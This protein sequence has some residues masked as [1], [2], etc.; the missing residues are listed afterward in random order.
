VF[1][2][3]KNNKP[4]KDRAVFKLERKLPLRRVIGKLKADEIHEMVVANAPEIQKGEKGYPGQF[5]KAL[6]SFVE[7]LTAE[8]LDEME[9]I[10]EEWQS[11]GP[12]VDVRLK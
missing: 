12:P 5:Q 10:R 11:A 2:W 7:T 8:E 6:T 3:F 9:K 4:Y 1:T